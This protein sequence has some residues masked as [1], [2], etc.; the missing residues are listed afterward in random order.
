MY[1]DFIQYTA[2]STKRNL[3]SLE[4]EYVKCYIAGRLNDPSIQPMHI[5]Y[6]MHQSLFPEELDYFVE[7]MTKCKDIYIRLLE[8]TD[9]LT[10]AVKLDSIF[11]TLQ[12]LEPL[13]PDF[14]L[15]QGL[16]MFLEGVKDKCDELLLNPKEDCYQYHTIKKNGVCNCGNVCFS[17]NNALSA[18]QSTI[19]LHINSEDLD[20]I[21]E[22]FNNNIPKYRLMIEKPLNEL[23]EL[24]TSPGSKGRLVLHIKKKLVIPYNI[25]TLPYVQQ[26][27]QELLFK[28]PSNAKS[29]RKRH[30][31]PSNEEPPHK[32]QKQQ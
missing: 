15:L 14:G 13:Y 28:L 21:Q 1:P 27:A 24:T 32:I 5:P 25:Q 20:H 22:Q 29:A 3:A 19:N 31:P 30:L 12:K 9:Y 10:I 11:E 23:I 17:I 16:R 26:A 7:I 18:P 2:L 8:K 4:K 6:L